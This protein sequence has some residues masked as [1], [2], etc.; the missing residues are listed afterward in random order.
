MGAS[1]SYNLQINPFKDR[2]EPQQMS[3]INLCSCHEPSELYV[4][5][6]NNQPAHKDS[7]NDANDKDISCYF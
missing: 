4:E 1:L 5:A 6:R 2:P 7:E 3:N